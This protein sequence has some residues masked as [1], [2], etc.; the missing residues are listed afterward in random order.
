MLCNYVSD[1]VLNDN[2]LNRVDLIH[3]ISGVQ[4][5]IAVYCDEN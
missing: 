2:G 5:D 4:K 3:D 1:I